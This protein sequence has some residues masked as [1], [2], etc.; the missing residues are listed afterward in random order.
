MARGKRLAGGYVHIGERVL[1]DLRAQWEARGRAG[2][3]LR[4][5]RGVTLGVSIAGFGATAAFTP[6]TAPPELSKYDDA[7]RVMEY[8]GDDHVIA[9]SDA[10]DF[11]PDFRVHHLSG[12]ARFHVFSIPG[13]NGR[14]FPH[15]IA[16]V[17]MIDGHCDGEPAN[18]LLFL[19]GTFG[20]P[21]RHSSQRPTATAYTPSSPEGFRY[22]FHVS[23]GSAPETFDPIAGYELESTERGLLADTLLVVA[24]G[25][26]DKP[27]DVVECDFVAQVHGTL[28]RGDEARMHYSSAITLPAPAFTVCGAPLVLAE[29]GAEQVS[30]W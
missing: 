10:P 16:Y 1:T 21:T 11:G 19:M 12:R 3:R 9:S 2:K 13:S 20:H 24:R 18:G 27:R 22:A 4:P 26:L 6:R 14:D 8:L 7:S 15:H 17:A 30:A 5:R 25:A 28:H 29:S 23:R